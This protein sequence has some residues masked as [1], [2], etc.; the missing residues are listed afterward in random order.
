MA[1]GQ[2]AAIIFA[3]IS[4]VILLVTFYLLRRTYLAKMA[5]AARVLGIGRQLASELERQGRLPSAL[6]LGHPV[7]ISA[8]ALEIF[9]EC[10]RENPA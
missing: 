7:A 10:K 2:I 1:D 9:L 6:A 3:S 8:R 4:A 5:E